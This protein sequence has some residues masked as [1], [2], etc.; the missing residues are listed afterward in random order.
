[1]VTPKALIRVSRV[2]R[3]REGNISPNLISAEFLEIRIF[4][5]FVFKATAEASIACVVDTGLG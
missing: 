5:L 4:D 3:Q 2:I 1:M